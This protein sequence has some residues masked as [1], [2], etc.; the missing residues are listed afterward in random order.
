MTER[1]FIIVSRYHPDMYQVTDMY[2]TSIDGRLNLTIGLFGWTVKPGAALQ[3]DE[4]EAAAA[5]LLV[6]DALGET[7][8][9]ETVPA[10]DTGHQS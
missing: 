3:L 8:S 2:L 7:Y 9:V 1:K 6:A 4:V 5:L 10:P